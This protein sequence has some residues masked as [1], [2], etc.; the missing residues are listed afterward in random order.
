MTPEEQVQQE[1]IEHIASLLPLTKSALRPKVTPLVPLL[2][3][4]R[5]ARDTPSHLKKLPSDTLFTQGK[6]VS[7]ILSKEEV[8]SLDRTIF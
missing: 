7:H 6:E 2:E 4:I 3:D 5:K 1:K 8:D